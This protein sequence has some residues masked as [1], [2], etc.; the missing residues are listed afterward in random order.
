MKEN[1]K[2]VLY[3][4]L[5]LILFFGLVTAGWAYGR[6]KNNSP[7]ATTAVTPPVI[8]VVK[9][10]SWN[11]PPGY[12]VKGNLHSMIYHVPGGEYYDRTNAQNSLCFD[13]TADAEAGGF[14]S[15]L[16]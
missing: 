9:V 7:S 8:H 16:R 2:K 13:N 15:S 11:C 14:R 3:P 6:F 1:I 12:P 4:F 10:N 5:A